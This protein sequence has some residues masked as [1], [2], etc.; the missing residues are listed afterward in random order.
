MITAYYVRDFM[1]SPAV[2][3]PVTA[4]LL[5]AAMTLRSS[6]IRHLLIVDGNRV[7]GIISDRD[8]QRCAP[9]RLVPITEEKYNSIFENTPLTRVMTREP[10]SISPD[11][12]LADAVAILQEGKFGCLPVVENGNLVGIITRHDLMAALLHVLNGKVGPLDS[13]TSS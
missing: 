1:S 13:V 9:S 2:T 12:L 10:Q 5:D 8:I 7:V 4:R 11:T 6:S 3:M